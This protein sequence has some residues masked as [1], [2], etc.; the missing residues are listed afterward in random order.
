MPASERDA[1]PQP[2]AHAHGL[3]GP[4]AVS[5]L[6]QLSGL[7][8]LSMSDLLA[9]CAAATAVSTPPR[10]PAPA[11]KRPTERRRPSC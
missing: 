8:H 11:G 1:Q 9:S 3:P 6:S 4:S 7:S 10:D 2:H 5:G